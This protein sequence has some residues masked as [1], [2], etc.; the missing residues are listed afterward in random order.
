MAEVVTEVRDGNDDV[1]LAAK[2]T[3]KRSTYHRNVL[4]FGGLHIV[5]GRPCSEKI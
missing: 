5:A 4:R 3:R 2:L 1:S